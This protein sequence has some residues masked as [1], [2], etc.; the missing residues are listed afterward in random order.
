MKLKGELSNH[1]GNVLA[2]VS[3]RKFATGG[4][5]EIADNY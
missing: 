2:V 5:T 4:G 3:D 1:L